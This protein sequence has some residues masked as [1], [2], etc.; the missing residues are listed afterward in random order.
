MSTSVSCR[1]RRRLLRSQEKLLLCVE[2]TAAASFIRNFRG[3]N[4]SSEQSSLESDSSNCSSVQLEECLS[5]ETLNYLATHSFSMSRRATNRDRSERRCV[6]RSFFNMFQGR[7]CRVLESDS[8]AWKRPS[9]S[10]EQLAK[11]LHCIVMASKGFV[12]ALPTTTAV[13]LHGDSQEL[14]R[15]Q[16]FF[17]WA[18]TREISTPGL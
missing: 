3:C 7:H 5:V 18:R 6:T 1:A 4:V 8:M 13:D 9:T 10:L 2:M 15:R 12:K 14:L 11:V 17:I 16:L